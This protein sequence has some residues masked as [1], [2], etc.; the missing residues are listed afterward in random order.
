MPPAGHHG[1]TVRKADNVEGDQAGRAIKHTGRAEQR[2]R[3]GQRHI[4]DV[5]INAR[6]AV[7]GVFLTVPP[8]KK[9]KG[10][11][12]R[13]AMHGKP[14]NGGD[15]QRGGVFRRQLH[16][17]EGLCDDGRCN[18]IK[19]EVVR[20]PSG[21]FFIKPGFICKKTDGDHDIQNKHLLRGSRHIF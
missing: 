15:Q 18:D 8:A 19:K 2:L 17:E 16:G 4:A 21:L 13:S 1:Y 20:H 12:D 3:H 11:Q 9:G 5:P 6:V 10:D 7:N 14:A